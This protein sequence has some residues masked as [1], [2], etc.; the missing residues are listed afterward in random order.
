MKTHLPSGALTAFA[1]WKVL[2]ARVGLAAEPSKREHCRY[3]LSKAV[4]PAQARA[5]KFQS[6]C[7]LG[8][9]MEDT[10][11]QWC[12]KNDVTCST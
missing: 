6:D 7:R 3:A 2:K 4:L 8:K 11:A 5:G 9:P 1:L 12:F 10:E